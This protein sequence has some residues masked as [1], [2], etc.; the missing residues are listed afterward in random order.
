MLCGDL[1]QKAVLLASCHLDEL[2]LLIGPRL[3]PEDFRAGM[4]LFKQMDAGVGTVTSSWI[5]WQGWMLPGSSA[6]SASRLKFPPDV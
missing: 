6:T 1:V 5:L 3:S 4:R 2:Q